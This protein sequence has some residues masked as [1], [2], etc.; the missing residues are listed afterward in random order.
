MN[1]LQSQI[2]PPVLRL[3]G[4]S[5][6][7]PG[8]RALSDARL[9]VL[10]GEIHALIGEN[11]A[12]KSTLVK[13]LFGVYQPDTGMIE[14]NG[15]PV[16]ISSPHQAQQLGI[17]MV[18]QELNLI[19]A[20]DVGRNIYL[21]REPT[22]GASIIDWPKLYHNAEALLAQLGIHLNP[23]TL[24][25][26]LS[27]AQQQMVEIAHALAWKPSIVILDEPTSSLT[28]QEIDELFRILRDLK[29]SGVSILYISHRLEELQEI[30]DRA[31]VL[32]D[33]HYIATVDARR[34]TIPELIRMM[35]GRSL[36]QQFPKEDIGIG[37]EMLR[38]QGL[39]R[40]GVF[41]D[42]SFSVH[43]GEM[44]GLAGLVGAG[45]SEVARAIFGADPLDGGEVFVNGRKVEIHTPHDAVAVRIGL[46][47]ED[48]KT[49]GLVL[50]LPVKTNSTLTV[51]ERLS[52]MGIVH[53]AQR[54]TLARQA[55]TDLH[56]RTPSIAVRV[57]NLS[58]GNQQKVVLAKWLAAQS[59]VLIF[60]EPTRGIDVGA[61]V[62]VYHLMN[63][64][65]KEGVAILLISSELPE[66][67]GMSDRVLVMHEGK[68]VADIPRSAAN[69]ELIM[70]Y[71]SG[72]NG[73]E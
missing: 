48:R 58:G 41:Q 10:R 16:S 18:H 70:S 9:E 7:F 54:D 26:K 68:L 35:V 71:A 5:K 11:G 69:Q 8:V 37:A 13:I 62:E 46:L 29:A 52:R 57:R 15:K 64:L 28:S 59:K 56:I 4:V 60:D 61:K 22:R 6:S 14:L 45:R 31:T 27:V 65:A 2:A 25:R 38:V 53:G 30:A 50:V 39:T 63:Q 33:G 51:L 49:Q 20:L 67:L 19:P 66:V 32:R 12:G 23:R 1:E 55:V 73:D 36:E 34:A 40:T 43:S 47:P 44:V 21:G 72:K 24:V 17:S 3:E 42:I